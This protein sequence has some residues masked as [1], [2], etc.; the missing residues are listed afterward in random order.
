MGSIRWK[1]VKRTGDDILKNH[2]DEITEDFGKNKEAVNRYVS[3]ITKKYRNKLAG[4]VTRE[5]YK[6]EHGISGTYVS[7]EE[8]KSRRRKR[9]RK[10][11]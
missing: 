11:Y 6:I 5:K 4:Y 9:K 7:G 2:Y 10:I 3:A 1:S 8:K